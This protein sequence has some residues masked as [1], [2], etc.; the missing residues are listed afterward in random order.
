[1]P[2]LDVKRFEFQA[3]LF[4]ATLC[5]SM[6]PR[7]Q[8][9][10]TVVFN[11]IMYHPPGDEASLEWIELHSQMAVDMDLTGWLIGNGVFFE[12]PAGTILRGGGYLVVASNPTALAEATGFGGALGPFTG[13]LDNSGERLELF[14]NAGRVMNSMRYND[15]GDWPLA[16]DGSGL[17]LAK[18]RPQ[19]ASAPAENW[20]AST[21]VGGT[22]GAPNFPADDD[23][24]TFPAAL[25]SYWSFDGSARDVVS[26][27][28][29]SAGNTTTLVAGLVGDG[30]FSF[31]NTNAAFINVGSGGFSTTTGVT[32]EAV[33]APEW[34]GADGDADMIFR[35]EDGSNRILFGFQHDGNDDGRS[36]PPLAPGY[37][38]PVLS[39]GI[40]VDGDYGELDMPLDGA[41]GRPRLSDLA[42]GRAHHLA[43]TYDST[44]GT[45]SIYVDGV[46]VFSHTLRAGARIT[47]GG[48]T[49]AY[50]GNMSGRAQ[51]YNGRIDEVAFW[52]RSLSAQEISAHSRGAALG[53]NYF[54]GTGEDGEAPTLRFNEYVVRN[55]DDYWLEI[56]NWGAAPVP[57]EGLSI[58][59]RDL[60]G[61]FEWQGGTLAAGDLLVVD[62]STVGLQVRSDETLFLFSRDGTQVADAVDVREPHRGRVAHARDAATPPRWLVPSTPTPGATNMFQLHDEIVINEIHYHPFAQ[63]AVPDIFDESLLL[64]MEAEWRYNADGNDLQTSWRLP[65][66][67]DGGWERGDALLYNENANLPGPKNTLIELGPITFYFR[68]TFEFDGILEQSELFLRTIVDDGAVFYLNGIEVLRVN[69]PAGVISASTLASPGVSDAVVNG[70]FTLPTVA[71]RQGTNTLAVEVHQGSSNSSDVVFGAELSAAVLVEEGHPYR[72]SPESWVELFNKSARTVD[73][74]G[75][76]LDR[77]IDYRFP[78]G[79]TMAPGEHL[80]VAG[81]RRFLEDKL[82]GVRILGDFSGRLSHRSD[83]IV[84]RDGVGNPADEVEYFD[85]GRWSSV[86]DGGGS[87]LELRDVHADNSKGESWAPSDESD[88]MPWRSYSYQAVARTVVGPEQWREFVVGLLDAGEA[89]IDDFSVRD[90]AA[91]TELLNNGDFED[92]DDRWRFLGTHRHSEVIDDPNNAG[93]KI[94]HLV[95]TGSTEHMHNHLETTL[96]SSISNGRTYRIAFRA[97]WLSG[98]NQLNT[99]LYFNRCARTTLLGRPEQSGTPGARNS[100]FTNNAGPTFEALRHAPVVPNAG[101][102]VVVHIDVADPD[103]VAA[104]ELVYSVAGGPWQRAA[105]SPQQDGGFTAAIPGQSAGRIVQFYVEGEDNR[106]ALASFPA[107]G[108]DSRA[109]YKVNDGQARS[110]PLPNFRILM[111]AADAGFLH[112]DTN[113][114]SNERLGATV[115]WRE[116]EVFYDVRVR[117]KGSQRGRPG[118]SR[119]SFSVRFQPD[120][121]FRGVHRSVSL[122]RSGG[123]GIGAG[124]TGQDEIIVKHTVTR[125]GLPGM[126]DDL[127]WLVAPQQAQ[128]GPCLVMM[129]KFTSVF[130]DAQY[131]DG[132]DGTIHKVELIYYP[133]TTVD[134]NPESLKRPLPDVVIGTDLRDLGDDKEVYRWNFLIENNAEK[135]EY[136]DFIQLCKTL[137]RSGSALDN[138]IDAIF[139]VDAVTRMYAAHSLCGISDTYWVAAN[140]HNVL[141]YQ[142][143]SD[144]RFLM[145]PWDNDVAFTRS[146]TS[147]LWGGPNIAKLYSFP[148]FRRLFFVHLKDMVDDYYNLDY[149]TRWTE[150]YGTLVQE[151]SSF[152]TVRRYVGDRSAHVRRSLPAVVPFA[153]TTGGG[154]GITVDTLETTL[155][156]TAWVDVKT[157]AVLGDDDA[158]P[159]EWSDTDSWRL[160]ARLRPGLNTVQVVGLDAQ[161]DLVASDSIRVNSTVTFDPP[162]ITQVL[163]PSAEIGTE[164]VIEGESFHRDVEVTFGGT[165]SES[166]NL[167]VAG[168]PGTIRATV[169]ARVPG[170][171]DLVVENIDGVASMP[172]SFNILESSGVF[173]RGDSNGDGVID[174]ADAL[175]TIYHL[176]AGRPIDCSD[177]AD[178]DDNETLDILDILRTLDWLFIGGPALPEPFTH[179]G[180]DPTDNGPLGCER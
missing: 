110:G 112:R 8:A 56:I 131:Q 34:T 16:A 72:Q 2:R 99:R 1:M 19:L 101:E 143:P 132:G 122:D 49:S 156:G 73:L 151:E 176:F 121:L 67:N 167:V 42:D 141:F 27:N 70:P 74:T 142:R 180:T 126:Y 134:G 169:P 174:I 75:W 108:P 32:L 116:S 154:G 81:D 139:D 31:D 90:V 128:N 119:V 40:N 150:H 57:L 18:R 71:L 62:A 59:S 83:R 135:D 130:L 114:M 94:L 125:G 24:P 7:L 175:A 178:S 36:D 41:D 3:I 159:T 118:G 146:P 148:R 63:D 168:T 93:N 157:V 115:Y 53:R 106:G 76:E 11:E 177:A 107:A 82:P 152:G 85:D 113:V 30:A 23:V 123:W 100:A 58:V 51:P 14:N 26:G 66:F 77:G 4:V 133:T 35:K 111:T 5:F 61:A 120:H 44:S 155:E 127:A 38:G 33:V 91:G 64:P 55:A 10:S 89:Y 102:P 117:L 17:S 163:P 12:F 173:R 87:S 92:D 166:V 164:I 21:A 6:A 50:I 80:L 171:V 140:F 98:S 84:L 29:G 138:S 96:R 105:M 145:F 88:Q 47:S 153:I 129:A 39:F 65:S 28:D 68:T 79:T 86:A 179:L 22:P 45:K 54:A 160:D 104:V 124:P 69:M 9:D 15:R 147:S 170:L 95:A 136:A 158:L 165:P 78:P 13:R 103:G 109:L 137:S 144:G 46:L 52:S 172:F 48:S 97:R 149:M 25:V 37:T 20:A 60:A 43:A 161:G 162:R